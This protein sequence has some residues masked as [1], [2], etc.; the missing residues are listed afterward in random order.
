MIRDLLAGLAAHPQFEK[1]LAGLAADDRHTLSL[2][3]LT[4]AAKGLILAL[5]WQK[6]S[7][8]QLILTDG[9]RQAESLLEAVNTFLTLLAPNS[10]PPPKNPPHA[11]HPPPNHH[12]PNPQNNHPPHSP[13]KPTNPR[14][15]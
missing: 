4:L 1:L 9:N 13:R 11:R 14:A 8:P 5:L 12:P 10:P 3:G 2:G 7:Q 15:T 6:N